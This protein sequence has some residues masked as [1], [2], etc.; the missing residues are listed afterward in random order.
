MQTK[1]PDRTGSVG[2]VVEARGHDNVGMKGDIERKKHLKLPQICMRPR[3]MGLHETK[4]N[5]ISTEK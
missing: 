5:S 3:G 1:P 2:Y 4:K